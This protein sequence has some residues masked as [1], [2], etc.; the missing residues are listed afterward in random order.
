MHLICNTIYHISLS[1]QDSWLVLDLWWKQLSAS[2]QDRWTTLSSALKSSGR[3]WFWPNLLKTISRSAQDWGWI[4]SQTH[5]SLFHSRLHTLLKKD[6]QS[7]NSQSTRVCGN[8]KAWSKAARTKLDIF[9][10]IREMRSVSVRRG[11]LRTDTLSERLDELHRELRLHTWQ[12]SV[13]GSA[14]FLSSATLSS[15]C[16]ASRSTSRGLDSG[17][18]YRDGNWNP[19]GSGQSKCSHKNMLMMLELV[20]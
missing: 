6:A 15:S 1:L 16:P 20:L 3:I 2:G 13:Y 7:S 10:S 19:E 11:Q 17:T 5:L 14:H 8:T 4:P 18:V 12:C 9:D